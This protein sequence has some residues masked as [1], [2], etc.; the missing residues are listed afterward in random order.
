MIREAELVRAGGKKKITLALTL[1]VSFRH[2][3]SN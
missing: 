2:W 3:V 1:T